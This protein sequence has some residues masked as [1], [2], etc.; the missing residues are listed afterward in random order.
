MPYVRLVGLA[1]EN[2]L[3]KMHALRNFKIIRFQ[4]LICD[5]PSANL[6]NGDVIVLCWWAGMEQWSAEEKERTKE[7]P[8][9]V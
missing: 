9:H 3:I 5:L 6:K 2:K 1:K 7:N 4:L 8:V